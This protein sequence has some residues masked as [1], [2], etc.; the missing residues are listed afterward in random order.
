MSYVEEMQGWIDSSESPEVRL[1]ESPP[2]VL[3]RNFLWVVAFCVASLM[4]IP[5]GVAWAASMLLR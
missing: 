1:P 5:V 2:L 4:A 3:T